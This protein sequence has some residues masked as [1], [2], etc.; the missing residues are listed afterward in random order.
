ML[1]P[2]MTLDAALRDVRHDDPRVREPAV[3]NLAPAL[4]AELDQPGPRWHATHEHTQGEAVRQAL[5]DR[6]DDAEPALRGHAATGLATLG[7][8]AVVETAE[9]WLELDGDDDEHEYL[10]QCGVIALSFLARAAIEAGVEPELRTRIESRIEAALGSE[11][12]DLRFQAG[13]ALVELR[14]AAAEPALVRALRDEE[15]HEVREGLLEAISMLDPPGAEAC[16]LLESILEGPDR[17]EGLGF[18][19]ALTL[20]AARRLIAR[21]RLMEA[22]DVRA[23]RDD[24]LEALAALGSADPAQVERVHRLARRVF[25]PG[26]TRV[27][28][29]YALARMVPDGEGDNPGLAMLQR[30]RWHPRPAVREAVADAFANLEQLASR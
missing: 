3:R 10:R 15:H 20:A 21:P 13:M 19:A 8:P 26:I 9:A 30:M 2:E 14:D 22:L 4:L 28:A 25:L 12:P 24:A 1:A 27:R 5:L 17:E 6:L 16:A 7:D 18:R 29:A 11:A 23:W